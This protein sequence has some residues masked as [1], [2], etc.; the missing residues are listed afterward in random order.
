MRELI[1]FPVHWN[2]AFV[3]RRNPGS[4]APGAN[5]RPIPSEPGLHPCHANCGL[6][7]AFERLR[8]LQRCCWEAQES[9]GAEWGHVGLYLVR[10][11]WVCLMKYVHPDYGSWGSPPLVTKKKWGRSRER[12]LHWVWWHRNSQGFWCLIHF[13]GS[14]APKCLWGSEP[15]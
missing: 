2:V 10:K 12:W 14:W 1:Y 7:F 3:L 9:S 15:S 5:L 13:R 8:G 6:A 4:A 11:Y